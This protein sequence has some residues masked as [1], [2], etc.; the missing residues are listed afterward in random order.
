MDNIT[1]RNLE[2]PVKE[3]LRIRAANHG[4]SLEEEVIQIL[5]QALLEDTQL[6]TN[7]A[8][9]IQK[10]FAQLGGVDDLTIVNREAMSKTSQF[11]YRL[12]VT[13]R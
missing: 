10:R 4:N 5:R 9:S 7:L 12:Q 3:R 1:I 11:E 2:E 8:E 13:F 6:S